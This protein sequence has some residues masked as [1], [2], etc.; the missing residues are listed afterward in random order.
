MPQ[1]APRSERFWEAIP[2]DEMT[3]E[4][5]D[6]L[7]DGCAKCCLEKF[8][9]EETGDI[10]YSC[11]ACAL[12]DLASCRCS[13]YP[14]RSERMPDCVTLTPATLANPRWLPDTCAY[15]LLAEGKPLPVW[16]PLLSGDADSVIRAGQSL[17]GR[18]VKPGP[19]VDP[20]MHLIDWIR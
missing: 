16:H 14:N 19:Q 6:A 10:I 18:A 4:E 15:R 1:Q 5:W 9:E 17:L 13:D 20:L 8:E 7:C 3:R 12:L 2:M 11:V